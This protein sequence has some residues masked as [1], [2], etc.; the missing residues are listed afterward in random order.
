MDI[1][2]SF[3]T[4][5][6][7]GKCLYLMTTRGLINLYP[8]IQVHLLDDD[9]RATIRDSVDSYPSI[10]AYLDDIPRAAWAQLGTQLIPIH[11]PKCIILS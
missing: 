5:E 9:E 10:Q 1:L 4:G 3:V 11:P 7:V 2:P 8:S 6:K